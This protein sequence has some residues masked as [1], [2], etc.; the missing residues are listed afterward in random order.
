MPFDIP[1]DPG[2]TVDGEWLVAPRIAGGYTFSGGT[3]PQGGNP[4]RKKNTPGCPCCGTTER[5]CTCA[6]ANGSLTMTV[7]GVTFLLGQL[8]T[9]Y[10]WQSAGG[11]SGPTFNVASKKFVFLNPC[12]NKTTLNTVYFRLDCANGVFSVSGQFGITICDN[13]C[14]YS[15]DFAGSFYFGA[16]TATVSSATCLPLLIEGTID[17]GWSMVPGYP[18]C[19]STGFTDSP[20]VGKTFTITKL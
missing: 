10:A 12:A 6:D 14:E 13:T 16:F 5:E 15:Y 9:S 3:A 1:D 8:G 7:D 4:A 20:L 17:T 2:Q 19:V 11:S 18:D